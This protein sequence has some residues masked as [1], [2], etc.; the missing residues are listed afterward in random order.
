MGKAPPPKD[1]SPL[2]TAPLAGPSLA[3][4]DRFTLASQRQWLTAAKRVDKLQRALYF[5][6][7]RSRNERTKQLLRA[8][9]FAAR[10]S[11]DVKHRSRIAEHQYTVDP[12]SLNGS[13]RVHRR[14]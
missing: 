8:W 9:R 4:L 6:L 11:F 1:E 3:E 7:A 12:L 14:I 5:G 10:Q 2:L 13:Q